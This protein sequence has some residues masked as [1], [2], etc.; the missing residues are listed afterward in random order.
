[1]KCPKSFTFGS[2]NK[3]SFKT[4]EPHWFFFSRCGSP[5]GL[6]L[7]ALQ[8]CFLSGSLVML[9]TFFW[10][11]RSLLVTQDV[12][13][14][15]GVHKCLFY[16]FFFEGFEPIWDPVSCFVVIP[17]LCFVLHTSSIVKWVCSFWNCA[18][19]FLCEHTCERGS[20]LW[21]RRRAFDLPPLLV[22]QADSSAVQQIRALT[23]SSASS[24]R[25]STSGKAG[26]AF[27]FRLKS[28]GKSLMDLDWC[29]SKEIERR[30]VHFL[31]PYFARTLLAGMWTTFQRLFP[32]LPRTSFEVLTPY[33]YLSDC[34]TKSIEK[35]TQTWKSKNQ[36]SAR[37][38]R[39]HVSATSLCPETPGVSI[40]HL[41]LTPHRTLEFNLPWAFADAACSSCNKW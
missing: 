31:F 17:M 1:M 10:K 40:F 19:G 35:K 3:V 38:R 4:V 23:R 15:P 21:S 24:A 11:L 14:E 32:H 9:M 8:Q 7:L 30:C 22:V 5:V 37:R 28:E 16:S 20:L 39:R 41:Y 2:D 26:N 29:K 34:S 33:K 12:S 25:T 27:A 36:L 6:V 18:G 13:Q